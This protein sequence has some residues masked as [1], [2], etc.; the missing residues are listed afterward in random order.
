MYFLFTN[1]EFDLTVLKATSTCVLLAAAYVLSLYIWRKDVTERDNPETVKRRFISV[2]IVCAVSPLLLWLLSTP[3]PKGHTLLELLG[4]RIPGFITAMLAPLVLTMVLFFGPLALQY[5]E[6]YLLLY[7]DFTFWL[8]AFQ[9]LYWIR[10]HVLA[11][12]TEEFVFRAC[13]LPLLVPCFGPVK[14]ILSAPAVF[15]LAHLHHAYEMI[16][17]G[18]TMKGALLVCGFQFIY[19]SV[20][21]I[22]CG[23][24]FIRTG[25]VIA[26]IIVHAFCNH[27]GFP[28]FAAI[29][30]FKSIP[31]RAAL[32]GCFLTG[33]IGWYWLVGSLTNP[34]IY[35][36][37]IYSF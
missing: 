2:S 20:F 5:K 27:M 35:H 16:Q 33:L 29:F 7:T 24:I 30:S 15:G 3:A 6:G 4:L 34:I 23:F 22:Y 21:G 26:V 17:Q 9:D 14:A 11:P 1:V 31:V 13:M 37:N 18:Q 19:T 36:N 10:S 32:I 25:H 12:V 8:E 28:D